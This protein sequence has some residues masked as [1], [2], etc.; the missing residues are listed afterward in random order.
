M[1]RFAE[2]PG[3][4]YK[5]IIDGLW[6]QLGEDDPRQYAWDMAYREVSTRTLV[7][8]DPATGV[9]SLPRDGEPDPLVPADTRRLLII[10]CVPA[11]HH[12]SMTPMLA[13]VW[14]TS[15]GLL[16]VARLPGRL[17]RP[18][19]HPGDPFEAPA[20]VRSRR[21]PPWRAPQALAA[22]VEWQ[23]VP[24]TIVRL[25][26]A[27][28]VPARLWVRCVR[29]GPREVDRVKLYR[30]SERHLASESADTLEPTYVRLDSVAALSYD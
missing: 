26:L 23:H 19:E 28:D 17:H 2:I 30:E 11:L 8:R 6:P 21:S 3:Q 27:D 12:R 29:H 7:Y 18:G 10:T 24:I 20:A 4:P 15:Y 25:L 14:Q 22:A 1:N 5:A 13:E 16:F 9:L